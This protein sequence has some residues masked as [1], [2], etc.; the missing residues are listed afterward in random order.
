[1]K[2]DMSEVYE[3]ADTGDSITYCRLCEQP[4]GVHAECCPIAYLEA[5]EPLHDEWRRTYRDCRDEGSFDEHVAA[6]DA[7]F[8]FLEDEQ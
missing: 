4:L 3:A 8:A 5:I 6:E 1:M 2:P 7:L